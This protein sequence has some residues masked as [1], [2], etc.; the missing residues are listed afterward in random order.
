MFCHVVLRSPCSTTA[1]I[2]RSILPWQIF[3]LFENLSGQPRQATFVN[4]VPLCCVTVTPFVHGGQNCDYHGSRGHSV[5]VALVN[6]YQ[7]CASCDLWANNCPLLGSRV[8]KT[9]KRQN[10]KISPGLQQRY[11]ACCLFIKIFQIK[12]LGL[13]R[14]LS[15][16]RSHVLYRLIY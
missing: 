2:S 1:H 10:K 3:G 15:I 7:V 16:E 8:T 12:V 5:K 9:N 13:E 6:C 14:A 11:L 4:L